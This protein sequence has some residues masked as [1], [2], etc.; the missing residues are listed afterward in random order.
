MLTQEALD[1]R[2]GDGVAKL[3]ELAFDLAVAPA[4]VLPR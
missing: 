1:R 3:E 2:P 4:G